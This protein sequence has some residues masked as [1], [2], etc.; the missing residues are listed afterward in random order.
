[1]P[2]QAKPYPPLSE[3][4]KQQPV[5]DYQNVEGTL[6]GFSLPPSLEGINV[7][8]YHLHLLS[9]D[10]T[11]GGHMLDFTMAA[12]TVEVDDSPEA[13]VV[14]SAAAAQAGMGTRK[15]SREEIERVEKDGK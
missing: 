4:V 6:V 13:R 7:P 8:G 5:F 3:V 1:V 14:F 10:G 2:A 15:A 12:G 11:Q 9:K